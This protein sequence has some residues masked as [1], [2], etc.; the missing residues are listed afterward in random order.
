M[1]ILIVVDIYPPEIS[2]AGHLM[3]ELAEG[4]KR[5]GH[6]ITVAASYPKH[7]LNSEAENNKPETFSV[8]DGIEVIRVK[9][10]PRRKINFLIRGI[11]QLLLPFLFFRKIKKYVASPVDMVIVY[12]PPLPL[13]LI[14]NK[15]KKHYGAKFILNVQDIFPQNA[16]D[17][18]ILKNKLLIK[19]F[20]SIERK[21]YKG[22]DIITF[23]SEGGRRFLIEKKGLPPE[24]VITLYNWIDPV[25][26]Q[27]PTKDISFRKRYG[28][29]G[30]FIFLFAGVMGPA[31][32]LDF[33]VEVAKEVSDIDDIVFLLVGDGM[34]KEKIQKMVSAYSLA[35]MAIKTLVPKEEYPFLLRD[36]DVGVV[37]LSTNNTTPF[38]PGKFLGYLAA[39]LPIVAFLNKESDGFYLIKKAN[40]GYAVV[41]NSP[42]RAAD[43]VRNIYNKRREL[44]GF[45]KSGR[46][47]LLNNFTVDACVTKLEKLF[48]KTDQSF[49]I[50]KNDVRQ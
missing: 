32:G 13:G 21:V 19:F 1:K 20:E 5:R 15:V 24:K 28:L 49:R 40:C 50:K 34:E 12:S 2:S 16:I 46:E 30:R 38:I 42:K 18:G 39:G 45:G 47:Y 33:L 35:N 27:N 44:Y 3:Q 36:A 37:C 25:P 7:Y 29:E 8:E 4:L 41:S 26:Y 31:Q 10:L 14:G 11:S 6:Q 23:N 48:E 43:L 9:T 17:L 22:A